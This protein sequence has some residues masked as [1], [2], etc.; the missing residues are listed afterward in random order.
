MVRNAVYS[1]YNENIITHII[2]ITSFIKL[3]VQTSLIF[4]IDKYLLFLLIPFIVLLI[5][6]EFVLQT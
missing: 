2:L 1:H 3:Q 4:F 6:R 5:K